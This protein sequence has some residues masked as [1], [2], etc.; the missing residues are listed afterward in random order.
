MD[1]GERDL[2]QLLREAGAEELLELLR[3]HGEALDVPGARMALR[4]PYLTTEGIRLLLEAERLL[5]SLEVRRLLAQHPRTPEITALRLLP[6]LPWAD[7]LATT[8]NPRVSPRVRHHAEQALVTRLPGLAL[9]ERTSLA[10][11]ASQGVLLH[12]R[13]D[14]DPRV[15]QALLENPRATEGLIVPVAASEVSPPEILTLLA[16][17]PRWASRYEL[18]LALVRNARTP[19]AVALRLVW[20]LKRVHLRALIGDPRVPTQVKERARRA[21]ERERS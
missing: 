16:R 10:R 11:R 3:S 19:S 17:S 18:R 1:A 14:K 5:A 21:L 15:V 6:A 8:V 2:E 4:N 20:D 12:L 9:G 7:L 13:F